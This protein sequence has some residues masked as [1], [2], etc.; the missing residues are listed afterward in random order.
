MI[1]DSD[2]LLQ[3]YQQFNQEPPFVD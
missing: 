3:A 2:T 1:V